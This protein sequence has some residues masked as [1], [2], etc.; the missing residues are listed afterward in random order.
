M[1]HKCGI[2]LVYCQ[3]PETDDNID[4]LLQLDHF[5]F[6]AE[7]LVIQEKRKTIAA[8]KAFL[9]GVEHGFPNTQN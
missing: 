4:K 7:M 6:R 9:H 5:V 8:A 3:C 2:D 1:V